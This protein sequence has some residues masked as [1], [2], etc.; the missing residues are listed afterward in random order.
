MPYNKIRS[1]HIAHSKWQRAQDTGRYNGYTKD[2]ILA[3]IL[4]L[5]DCNGLD[6]ITKL[7]MEEWRKFN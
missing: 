5:L 2:D 6:I 3:D 7:A 4:D 1:F